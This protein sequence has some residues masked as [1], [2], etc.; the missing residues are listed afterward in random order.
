MVDC[1]F[2][3]TQNRYANHNQLVGCIR[4]VRGGKTNAN[5]GN[6]Q[7]NSHAVVMS[8]CPLTATRNSHAKHNQLVGHIH[9]VLIRYRERSVLKNPST[10]DDDY[11][12]I[13]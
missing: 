2:I 10:H 1:P 6:Q 5:I 9:R 8:D 13:K 12:S 11:S 3:A 4:V 7:W